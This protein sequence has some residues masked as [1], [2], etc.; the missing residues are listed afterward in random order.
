MGTAPRVTNTAPLVLGGVFLGAVTGGW[1]AA[2]MGSGSAHFPDFTGIPVALM[3][4]TVGAAAACS[5]VGSVDS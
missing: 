1:L 2:V 5:W 3:G 4:A